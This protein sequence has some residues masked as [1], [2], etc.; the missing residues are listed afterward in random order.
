MKTMKLITVAT[1]ALAAIGF[2]STSASAQSVTTGSQDI[3]LGFEINDGT[4]QGA[5]S[6]LEIDLGATSLFTSSYSVNSFSQVLGADLSSV[7]GANWAS[8]SDLVWGVGGV[9]SDGSVQN[10]FSLTSQVALKTGTNGNLA[11]PFGQVG[12][13]AAGLNSTPALSSPSAGSVPT[14]QSNG[15]TGA[16][17]ASGAVTTDDFRLSGFSGGGQSETATGPIGSL[18]L[19]TFTPN[20]ASRN[21]PP[22]TLDGAFSLAGSGSTATFSYLGAAP[23]SVPE[24]SAYALGICAVGLFV[25]LRRRNSIV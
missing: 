16:R 9:L 21:E 24:P 2:A 25:V 4:G 19:Y 5:T 23:A 18:N 15:W 8:R 17:T 10:N 6:N 22:A 13:L 14:S 7:Y 12:Q 11:N 20:T 1:L 3:I